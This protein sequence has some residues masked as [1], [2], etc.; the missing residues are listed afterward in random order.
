MRAASA[1]FND[2]AF[3]GDPCQH[4]VKPSRANAEV[5]K[6]RPPVGER[7]FHQKMITARGLNQ[8]AA[9]FDLAG[10]ATGIDIGEK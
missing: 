9:F 6:N 10:F 1:V 4:N 2:A 5:K 8:A 7:F 3:H